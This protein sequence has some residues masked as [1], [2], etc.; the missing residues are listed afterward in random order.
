LILG[1]DRFGGRRGFTAGRRRRDLYRCL[2]QRML[3]AA[4]RGGD[5]PVKPGELLLN[6]SALA[7]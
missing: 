7:L 2:G 3:C 6:K 4:F 5:F 1:Y